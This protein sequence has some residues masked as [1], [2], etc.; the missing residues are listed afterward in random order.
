MNLE[1][2]WLLVVALLA[3][4]L[5]SVFLLRRAM[6]GMCSECGHRSYAHRIDEHICE[7]LIGDWVTCGCERFTSAS[8]THPRITGSGARRRT[9]LT[10]PN[11]AEPALGSEVR[12]TVPSHE[13]QHP[14]NFPK[15][16]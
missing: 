4:G 2:S 11:R 3:S 1:L 14:T 8:T 13:G 15:A 9:S 10:A 16:S 6:T 12:P 7:S 5:G